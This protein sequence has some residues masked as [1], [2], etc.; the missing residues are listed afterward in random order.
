MR[1]YQGNMDTIVDGYNLIFCCGWEGTAKTS[2]A[3]EQARNRLI[4]ELAE[5]I[6]VESRAH[7]TIVFDAKKTP[8]KET[9][10]EYTASGFQVVFA[11][12]HEE[13]DSLIE[14]LI[15]TH[16]AP[17]SLT[18]VSND[19]R[20]KTAAR[21]RKAISVDCESWLRQLE[22]G[23]ATPPPPDLPVQKQVAGLEQVDWLAEF[24]FDENE[25]LEVDETSGKPL[26]EP[27]VFNPFPPGYGDDLIE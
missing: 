14:E 2:L 15:R 6:P 7:L 24:G 18:V 12:D 8:V 4:R 23:A 26:Q 9:Q 5:R 10:R 22:R 19:N 17:K 21:R 3:L 16:A 20:L 1:W 25:D 13:A 11:S 27:D